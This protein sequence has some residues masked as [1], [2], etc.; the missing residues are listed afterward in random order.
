MDGAQCC[1]APIVG[2]AEHRGHD[3]PMWART[4]RASDD[5]APT[6]GQLLMPTDATS[7]TPGSASTASCA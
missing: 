3:D 7:G 2:R 4:E 5:A 1:S 6:T